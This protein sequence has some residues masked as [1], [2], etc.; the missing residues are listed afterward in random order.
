MSGVTRFPARAT[1]PADRMAGF[2]AHLRLNGLAL[3]VNETA[4]ALAAAAVVNPTDAAEM[5]LAL[6]AV[7]AGTREETALFDDLFA[8]WWLNRGRERPGEAQ[9]SA[10]PGRP[11]HRHSP[12][13]TEALSALGR[14]QA[15]RPEGGEGAAEQS[16]EGRLVGSRIARLNRTDLRELVSPED[17]VAA[18]DTARRIAQAIRDRRS[19]RLKADRRGARLDLRRIARD[20]VATGGE[21]LRLYRRS[22]PDRPASIVALCD[23]SGS[24]TVYARVFLSFLKGLIGANL[25]ADAY[26]FH[27][28]LV[29]ITDALRDPDPLRAVNRLGLMAQGF[30]GGTKIGGA[31]AAFNR[32]Y[33]KARVNGRSVVIVLSDGYDTD[34]P[35]L[36]A[37]ELAQLKKRGCRIVWLNPL[38]GWRDYAPVARGMAAALPHLDHFAAANTLDALAAL[39]PELSRL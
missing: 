20:S 35:D 22:R 1:G 18:E 25:R 31:L 34:P 21:P 28:R 37:R 32:G 15:D 3:G 39:E 36:I 19:R 12:F 38:K 8:A 16:G 10:T 4:T 5:R 13:V 23:V 29:R 26:L 14:G 30:G 24:M 27:T 7:C 9:T 2:M 33:A 6:K 11:E 17:I